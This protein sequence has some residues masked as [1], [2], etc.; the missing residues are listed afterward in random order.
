[1]H[2]DYLFCEFGL[3]CFRPNNVKYYLQQCYQIQYEYLTITMIIL[4][5]LLRHVLCYVSDPPRTSVRLNSRSWTRAD[6][7]RLSTSLCKAL[8]DNDEAAAHHLLS[9]QFSPCLHKH[10]CVREMLSLIIRSPKNF[11]IEHNYRRCLLPSQ[12][13]HCH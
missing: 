4:S 6:A 11:I 8:I 3:I 10:S 7:L 1:M 12:T 2:F 9:H 5:C 13:V